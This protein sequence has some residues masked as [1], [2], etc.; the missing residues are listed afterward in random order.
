MKRFCVLLII[1]S[2]LVGCK[3]QQ[4]ATESLYLS[5]IR[6]DIPFAVSE[7]K[8]LRDNIYTF[9]CDRL[10]NYEPDDVIDAEGVAY[11]YRSD[12]QQGPS[13]QSELVIWRNIVFNMRHKR[14][15]C[16]DRYVRDGKTWGT[17][18]V[19]Q[20]ACKRYQKSDVFHWDVTD[21]R[22]VNHISGALD[23]FTDLS[24]EILNNGKTL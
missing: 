7:L 23:G 8:P 22:L 6:H 17:V 1:L 24:V 15:V 18:C 19:L 5:D 14:V 9:T 21:I 13:R 12:F 11:V 16:I 10:V 20:S 2:A 4:A 3:V